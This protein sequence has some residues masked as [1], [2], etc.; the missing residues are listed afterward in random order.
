ML[1]ATHVSLVLVADGSK[2][3]SGGGWW[4]PLRVGAI[5]HLLISS[6]WVT[7]ESRH[8]FHNSKTRQNYVKV[9]LRIVAFHLADVSGA[10]TVV[11]RGGGG[12]AKPALCPVIYLSNDEFIVNLTFPRLEG[13][14]VGLF[15]VHSLPYTHLPLA[16]TSIIKPSGS[17]CDIAHDGGTTDKRSGNNSFGDVGSIAVVMGKSDE[18]QGFHKANA[19]Q[20]WLLGYEFPATLFLITPESITIVTTK[21]K[22]AY[23]EPLKGGK[24]PLEIVVRGKDAEENAKQFER[25]LDTIKNAGKRVGVITKEQSSGPRLKRSILAQPFLRSWL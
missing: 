4:R 23:L 10:Q 25:C 2:P 11:Q 13:R 24:I 5:C 9:V 8:L 18:T 19:M 21:K 16:A 12:I 1:R 3:A 20:F 17:I 7:F 6:A 14:D 22:A 15:A